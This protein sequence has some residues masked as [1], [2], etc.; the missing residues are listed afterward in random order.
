MNI[1]YYGHSCFLVD[2]KGVKIL[3]DPFITPNPIVDGVDVNSIEADFILISMGMRIM[4]RMLNQ[5]QK[6]QALNSFQIL[7]SF[8]G[9]EQ[10]VLNMD[11]H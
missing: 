5:L 8:P 10:K 7:K 11:T 2:L 9:L 3:F 6:E 4:L 1:T